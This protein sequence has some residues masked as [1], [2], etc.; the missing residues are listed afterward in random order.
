[1]PFLLSLFLTLSAVM[2]FFYG[3]LINDYNIAIPNVLGFSFGV[4]QMV[5]YAKYR[6][7]GRTNE[8]KF[9]QVQ[10]QVV[11]LDEQK[12]PELSEEIIEIVKLS[13]LLRSEKIQVPPQLNSHE[14]EAQ[15][16]QNLPNGIEV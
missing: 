10:K 5:L 2:W 7:S 16:H 4:I 11:V 1:M 9:L 8:Q 15:Q 3:L 13:A 6:N 14:V 12:I